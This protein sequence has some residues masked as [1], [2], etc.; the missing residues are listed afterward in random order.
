M[1]TPWPNTRGGFFREKDHEGQWIDYGAAVAGGLQ[2]VPDGE[3][4]ETLAGDYEQMA[5]S[6]M[7]MSDTP[8]SFDKMMEC[9]EGIAA[10]ANAAP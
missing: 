3:F 9:C 6:G 5:E 10:R 8:P 2:L 4:L 1:A 7:L